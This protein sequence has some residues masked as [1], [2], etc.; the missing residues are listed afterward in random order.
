M[1]AFADTVWEN[2]IVPRLCAPDFSCPEDITAEWRR[3]VRGR[4]ILA[5]NFALG[6]LYLLGLEVY[7]LTNKATDIDRCVLAEEWQALEQLIDRTDFLRGN[8]PFLDSLKA[9]PHLSQHPGAIFAGPAGVRFKG[10]P[11]NFTHVLP[12]DVFCQRPQV[13]HIHGAWLYT[14]AAGAYTGANSFARRDVLERLKALFRET[15]NS[16]FL[17]TINVGE[18][19]DDDEARMATLILASV[20]TDRVR[21]EI[22]DIEDIIAPPCMVDKHL[23]IMH[24]ERGKSMTYSERLPMFSFYKHSAVHADSVVA[25]MK[26]FYTES[27]TEKNPGTIAFKLHEI[28]SRPKYAPPFRERCSECRVAV[29]AGMETADRVTECARLGGFPFTATEKRVFD[30]DMFT[31]AKMAHHLA[32]HSKRRKQTHSASPLL[33]PHSAAAQ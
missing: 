17:S 15:A 1:Q 9:T 13:W 8:R 21:S 11:A 16:M 3:L 28:E 18:T 30:L 10:E 6:I 24:P 33:P 32:R 25:A 2:L 19:L 22:V 31:P 20:H 7:A 4:T 29:F 27:T 5:P 26:K 14:D 23:K 12:L